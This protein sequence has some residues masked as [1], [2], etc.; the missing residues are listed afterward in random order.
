MLH[1][2]KLVGADAQRLGW[3]ARAKAGPLAGFIAP[4]VIEVGADPSSMPEC[5][6][7]SVAAIHRLQDAADYRAMLQAWFGLLTVG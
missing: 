7:S 5:S 2:G 1:D 3:L 4:N 6:S